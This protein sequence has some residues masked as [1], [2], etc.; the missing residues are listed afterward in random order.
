MIT[1]GESALVASSPRALRSIALL[2][3]RPMSAIF[4]GVT[5]AACSPELSISLGVRD[6]GCESSSLVS[7]RSAALVVTAG[8]CGEPGAPIASVTAL[9]G[10][11]PSLAP[12]SYCLS[13][14]SYVRDTS[15]S[16]CRLLALDR[17]T[18][19]LPEARDPVSLDLACD[20]ASSPMHDPLLFAG[21]GCNG[22]CDVSRCV[23]TGAC[24]V[25]LAS[26]SCP[27]P[28]DATEL[29]IG[30]EYVCALD[31]MRRR[32]RCWGDGVDDAVGLLHDD[33]TT[34][35]APD[36]TPTVAA[37]VITRRPD[38]ASLDLFVGSD[39]FLC[40]NTATMPT[41]AG[42]R[43]RCGDWFFDQTVVVRARIAAAGRDFFCSGQR[44]SVCR[45][46]NDARSPVSLPLEYPIQLAAG[47]DVVCVLGGGGIQCL[48]PWACPVDS[49]TCAA[50]GPFIRPPEALVGND[51]DPG[52]FV[53]DAGWDRACAIDGRGRT[54]CWGLVDDNADGLPVPPSGSG[55]VW[56]PRLITD[57]GAGVEPLG[58]RAR[59]VSVGAEHICLR[60]DAGGVACGVLEAVPRG[61]RLS[62]VERFPGDEEVRAFAAGAHGVTC[63]VR[64]ALRGT[65][66]ECFQLAGFEGG[67]AMLG[68]GHTRDVV[69]GSVDPDRADLAVC[70]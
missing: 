1:D 24:D 17:E 58:I 59:E 67:N 65:R 6:G 16:V 61:L 29:A 70:P 37:E 56:Q 21:A 7:G 28:V 22:A 20:D 11:V 46:A 68:R 26:S 53:M 52:W 42:L 3:L 40:G 32:V 9:P 33:E 66:V 45:F 50:T 57:M 30:D 23:C 34:M 69:L 31:T 54:A 64:P 8:A 44:A 38:Q 10:A 2:R 35:R 27:D 18:R 5:V 47:S 25:T 12:G 49:P 39:S 60:L 55:A 43:L 19:T 36:D 48:D 41:D 4:V 62:R 63:A 15:A 13:A 51:A 14:L